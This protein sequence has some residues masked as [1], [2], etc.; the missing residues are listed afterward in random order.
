MNKVQKFVPKP[1]AKEG[2]RFDN[3]ITPALLDFIGGEIVDG[4][5]TGP[6]QYDDT[7]NGFRLYTLEGLSYIIT[8]ADYIMKGVKGE[9]YPCKAEVLF[10]SYDEVKD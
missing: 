10:A 3:R 7:V 9:L 1:I 5:Y 6:I 2:I 8:E 4:M